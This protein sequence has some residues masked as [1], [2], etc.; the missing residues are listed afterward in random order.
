[1]SSTTAVQ[2]ESTEL[3]HKVELKI[4]CQDLPS[5]DYMSKSDPMVV[6]FIK[7]GDSY[8]ELGRTESVTDDNNP[9][10]TT[11]IVMDYYFETVQNLKFA[12]YDVDS[13]S[14]KL[15]S[16]DFVG[17]A[18]AS[19]GEIVGHKHSKKA[20]T[21]TNPSK[22]D[23]AM[24]TIKIVV[25]ELGQLNANIKFS[26]AASNLDKKD[27]FGKSDPYIVISKAR[28]D[29]EWMPVHKTETVMKNLNPTFAPFVVPLQSLCNGDVNR[30][31]KFECFD[32][33][34]SGDHDFIGEFT[35]DVEQLTNGDKTVFEFK[36]PAKKKK[37]NYKNSGTL[38]FSAV[39]VITVASFLD[40]IKAGLEISLMV[41]IDFTASNGD[42]LY[43]GSLHYQNPYQPND[44]QKAIVAVGEL[45]AN[46]D[47][48]KLFPVYG[49]GAKYRNPKD[50]K[51]APA[52]SHCFPAN[53]N[54]ED[55]NC[56]GVQGILDAYYTAVNNVTFFGPTN[57]SPILQKAIDAAKGEPN[58][59]HVVLILTD[60]VITDRDKAIDKIVEASTLPI[61]IIIVGIGSASFTDM[62]ILDGDNEGLIDSNGTRASRDIVQFVSFRD[63]IHAPTAKLAQEV[64]AE[65]PEQLVSFMTSKSITPDDIAALV[66]DDNDD[67]EQPSSSSSSSHTQQLAQKV[68]DSVQV[69]SED[70][71]PPAYEG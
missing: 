69:A 7:E 67:D 18:L 52:V 58:V 56:N 55:P 54:D 25:E 45:V 49:F 48:D 39:E 12:V 60:G 40:Y 26:V 35:T 71:L 63:F 5:M 3:M 50:P 36:D 46:Y 19:L 42:R 31:L 53:L 34:R 6:V 51:A 33:D 44:Y 8:V 17:Q 13:A 59:Y 65:I 22:G 66:D 68:Q 28:E 64:L 1:M 37:K 41:A 24:G 11:P 70:E 57:F 30:P 38:T 9:Q 62:D 2:Y 43:S 21:L 15:D 4:S 10:F 47:S 23:G 27:F 29:G 20:F 16:H 32:W 61:S 14:A